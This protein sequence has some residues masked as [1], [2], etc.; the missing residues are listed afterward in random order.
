M[1]MGLPIIGLMDRDIRKHIKLAV[2]RLS[3]KQKE[4]TRF[5]VSKLVICLN[6]YSFRYYRHSKN[7]NDIEY[8]WQSRYFLFIIDN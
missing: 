8:P 2:K 3:K 7:L 5:Y 4:G 1:K 6:K